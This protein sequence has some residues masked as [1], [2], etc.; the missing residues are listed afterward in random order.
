LAER[1]VFDAI[2]QP[3]FGDLFPGA[4]LEAYHYDGELATG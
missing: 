3:S 4:T 2:V 1:D